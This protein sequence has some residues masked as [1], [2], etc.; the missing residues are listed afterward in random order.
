MAATNDCPSAL[1]RV[2]AASA[3]LEVLSVDLT[4]W[5]F[6]VLLASGPPRRHPMDEWS[7]RGKRKMRSNINM[8][9]GPD[10]EPSWLGLARSALVV[11]AP[12]RLTSQM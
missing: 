3:L 6:L 4:P 11:R 5:H 7:Q 8:R 1:V 10:A 9:I 12:G 2:V